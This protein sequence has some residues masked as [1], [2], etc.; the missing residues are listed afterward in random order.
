MTQWIRDKPELVPGNYREIFTEAC[1]RVG[2]DG[3][4]QKFQGRGIDPAHHPLRDRIR[5][6]GCGHCQS[7]RVLVIYARWVVHPF[8]GDT[9][10]DYEVFCEACG[11]YTQ[12]AFAGND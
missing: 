4:E 10:W 11:K 6:H 8:S 9:Y 5:M 3:L 2:P 7:A 12:R 1:A